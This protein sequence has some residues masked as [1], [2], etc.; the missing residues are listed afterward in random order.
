MIIKYHKDAAF[1][2]A[3]K[4]LKLE[5]IVQ[6]KTSYKEEG[7]SYR[8]ILGFPNNTNMIFHYH[9]PYNCKYDI[10]NVKV[11][12]GYYKA[13]QTRL[14]LNI[15]N[16]EYNSKFF[17]YEKPAA[18][19]NMDLGVVKKM[20]SEIQNLVFVSGRNLPEDLDNAFITELE[21]AHPD[22]ADSFKAIQKEQYVLFAKKQLDY[23]PG[24]ISLN[25]DLSDP[26]NRNLSL[27][28][29]W[30]RMNDKINR[31]KNLLFK[32]KSANNESIEDSW[33]DLGNYS[34]ISLMVNRNKWEKK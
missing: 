17:A 1:V 21:K 14:A 6:L 34:I 3:F 12:I 28:G 19:L 24:N 18:L 25:S 9:N 11:L 23:G 4:D 20:T 2:A 22:L 8:F 32:K 29:I 30:F 13:V 16:P 33:L 31:V 10:E 7:D 15:N 5:D 26:D 27:Y